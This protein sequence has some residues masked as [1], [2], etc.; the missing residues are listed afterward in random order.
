MLLRTAFLL[1]F[2][3][4]MVGPSP[5]SA[6]Q[7]KKCDN[8]TSVPER[9]SCLNSNIILLNSVVETVTDELRKAV[10]KLNERVDQVK[11]TPAPDLSNYVQFGVS[12]V[13]LHSQAWSTYCI[14]HNTS[15]ADHIHARPCNETGAQDFV[16]DRR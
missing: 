14:D 6:A 3:V 10:I 7:L 13:R 5:A 4:T 12:K 15:N 11:P 2:A 16:L 1:A 9:I 8:I